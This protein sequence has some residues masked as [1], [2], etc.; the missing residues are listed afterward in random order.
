M[1]LYMLIGSFEPTDPDSGNYKFYPW[2]YGFKLFATVA[3][4]W[5]VWPLYK[6]MVK[7]IGLQ[8]ISIGIIGAAIWI[9]VCHLELERTYL[10]PL[11]KQFGLDRY[12]G[13]QTRSAFNPFVHLAGSSAGI[14]LYLIVR[15]TGLALVIP[16]MEEYFLRGFLMRYV[17]AEKWWKHPIGSVT[18]GSAIAGTIVPMLMHPGELIAAAIW[19]SLIT[20]LYIRTKNLWE[21]IAAHSTTNLL[22]GIYVVVFGAWQLV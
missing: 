8:G 11:L 14:V 7:P 20:V 10:D 1:F 4:L 16:I 13:S 21:C 17:A 12:L 9:G 2:I 5:L 3:A 22:I 15:G 19:F 6:P 18:I